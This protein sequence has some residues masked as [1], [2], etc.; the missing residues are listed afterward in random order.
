MN[1]VCYS[2]QESVPVVL[3]PDKIAVV[4]PCYKVSA[5]IL[6]VIGA[7]GTQ[8][9]RIYVVDDCCPEQTGNLVE[10]APLGSQVCVLRHTQN[11]GVGGAVLS[12]YAAAIA[13]GYEVIVKVDGDGQMDPALIPEFVTPILEGEADYTKGNRFFD[14][15][16]VQ[17]MPRVRLFGNS[18]LSFF[19]KF[20]TGYWQLFDPT[21]GYTAIHADVARHLPANKL[22]RRYFF[23][24]DMLF[25][26]NTLRA[27]VVDIPMEARY[28]EE[29]SNLRI[30]QAIGEFSI[31][32]ATNFLKRLFYNYYLRDLSL[33]SFELPVGVALFLIGSIYGAYHWLQS[34]L[35]DATTPAGTVTLVAVMILVGTQLILAF[36]GS[37]IA[38]VPS[39]PISRSLRL[40]GKQFSSMT[41][42][43]KRGSA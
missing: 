22:S 21:N 10:A 42:N 19:A 15:E 25:R 30:C 37:D 1:I 12:G 24:T 40:R 43:R 39:R 31:K 16:S 23:E 26:L 27:V 35:V 14:I 2:L 17:S 38:N 6:S 36:F 13:D 5:H 28:G 8:A 7:I 20:S 34:Y 3:Y 29:V 18:V 11:Q 33:A 41:N 4:I 9:G 32:H